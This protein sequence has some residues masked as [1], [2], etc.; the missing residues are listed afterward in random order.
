MVLVASQRH[1]YEGLTRLNKAINDWA[2]CALILKELRL[3]L[4]NHHLVFLLIF[5]PI[6]QVIILGYCLDP[7]VRNVRIAIADLSCTP[8]SRA[9]VRTFTDNRELFVPHLVFPDAR[10][11]A[12][13]LV[14]ESADAVVVIPSTFSGKLE[15]FH[16][17]EFQVLLNGVDAFTAKVARGY[18]QLIAAHAFPGRHTGIVETLVRVAFNPGLLSAWYFVP[19]VLGAA[20]T[21]SGTLVSS[22]S[23]LRERESG[24]LEQ[25]LVLPVTSA[26]LLVAKMVPLFGLLFADVCIAI[27]LTSYLFSLPNRGSM[28]LYL[29]FSAVYILVTI[30]LGSLMATVCSSQR[31]SQLLS[32]FINIPLILLSGSV[33][34]LESMPEALRVLS[35]ADPLRYYQIVARDILLKGLGPHEL[36]DEMLCLL[37]FCVGLLSI[38]IVRIRHQLS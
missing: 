19:G 33:V 15:R 22:A 34:P 12:S 25:L 28:V 38:C 6:V 31:Q 2:I 4:R 20:I 32:F 18:F 29:F 1:A 17:G 7:Q 37:G 3:T 11:V 24:T 16:V 5:P 14:S 8:E 13:E 26:E 23:M 9:L 27:M 21:L 30:S 35:L 36:G 10:Q